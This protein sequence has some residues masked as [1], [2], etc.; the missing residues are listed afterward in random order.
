M[1]EE[2]KALFESNWMDS[3][4]SAVERFNDVPELAWDV[5]EIVLDAFFGIEDE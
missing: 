5:F 4:E 1:E 3:R 2:L